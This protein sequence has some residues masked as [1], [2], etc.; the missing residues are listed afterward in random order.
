M[1]EANIAVILK[2]PVAPPAPP[3]ELPPEK[4]PIVPEEWKLPLILLGVGGIVALALTV[5]VPRKKKA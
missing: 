5:A 1:P 4:P 3:P 2:V